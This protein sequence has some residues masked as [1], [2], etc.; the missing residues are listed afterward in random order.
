MYTFAHT[1]LPNDGITNDEVDFV[2]KVS[3]KTQRSVPVVPLRRVHVGYKVVDQIVPVR[4]NVV[5][6]QNNKLNCHKV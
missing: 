2:P 1:Q 3:V 4:I 6:L 5:N